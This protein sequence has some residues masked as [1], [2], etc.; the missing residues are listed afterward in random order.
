MVTDFRVNTEE[1]NAQDL[2]RVGDYGPKGFLVTWE[3]FEK[4]G[5]DALGGS[6]GAVGYPRLAAGGTGGLTEALRAAAEAAGATV[7]TGGRNMATVAHRLVS[8]RV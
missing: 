1:M 4:S 7:R 2:P 3:S 8:E 5:S 6:R